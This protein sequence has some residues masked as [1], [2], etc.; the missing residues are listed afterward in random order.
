MK[1]LIL[2]K[3]IDLDS[4]PKVRHE[5]NDS[6]VSEYS[7]RYRQKSHGM[8]EPILFQLGERYL[9]ADGLHRITAMRS[10][11]LKASAFE[12]LKGSR[13]DCVKYALKANLHHGLRRTN[14]DK[15]RGVE[16]AFAEF[17]DLSD[18]AVADVAA[19]SASLVKDVRSELVLK[20]VI[21]PSRSRVGKD[22]KTYPNKKKPV[23]V[24]VQS[25]VV[26]ENDEEDTNKV[27]KPKQLQAPDKKQEPELDATGFPIPEEV[28]ELWKSRW[29]SI[30][31]LKQV[32][33]LRS[34]LKSLAESNKPLFQEVKFNPM[35]ADID[36]IYDGMKVA[37]PYAVCPKCQG[38]LADKCK[39]CNGRGLLSEF[40]YR[41]VPEEFRK[42]REKACKK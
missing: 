38:R 3:D 15:R 9:I 26:K 41:M 6:V 18:E 2:L 22:G 10:I 29:E 12:V 20:N 7:E 42:L 32:G 8:P 14:A 17:P 37:I 16:L 1:K 19:V 39:Q 23:T 36:R 25:E 31:A 13:S 11:G 33:Q 28:I 34:F 30:D 21:P 40:R 4:S 35:L 24:E 5:L 27:Q